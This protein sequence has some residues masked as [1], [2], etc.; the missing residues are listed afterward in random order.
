MRSLI[1]ELKL[2]DC[3]CKSSLITGPLKAEGFLRQEEAG[4][5]HKSEKRH[6]HQGVTCRCASEDGR[7]KRKWLREV[8]EPIVSK[9]KGTSLLQ[10]QK[11]LGTP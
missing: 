9:E 6:S 2:G 4:R 5:R 1:S 10:P 8:S 11:I 3:V 7:V